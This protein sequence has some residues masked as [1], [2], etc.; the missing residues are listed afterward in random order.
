VDPY[1]YVFGPSGSRYGTGS[2]QHQDKNLLFVTSLWLFIFQDWCKP[3]KEKY[4]KKHGILNV[5]DKKSRVRKSVVRIRGTGSRSRS[6]PKWHWS[7]T[8]PCSI[9]P[10]P[11]MLLSTPMC[12]LMLVDVTPGYAAFTLIWSA[13]HSRDNCRTVNI[14]AAG[15]V[16]VKNSWQCLVKF[17]FLA[18]FYL[19]TIFTIL[20]LPS[21]LCVKALDAS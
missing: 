6:I 9:F 21:W 4:A 20:C 7:T 18:L 3:F 19:L 17:L 10:L 15:E 1:P 5:T 11:D 8:L 16:Q 12:L 13:F 14:I 2:F